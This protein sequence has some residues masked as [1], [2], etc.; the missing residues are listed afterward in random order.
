MPKL[1]F[2]SNCTFLIEKTE[3]QTSDPHRTWAIAANSI[4]CHIPPKG[5]AKH[6]HKISHLEKF[7]QKKKRGG[8]EEE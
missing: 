6:K 7:H 1:F 2:I 3:R 4:S 8:E 5:Q